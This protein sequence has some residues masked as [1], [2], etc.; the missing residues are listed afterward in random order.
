MMLVSLNDL[1]CIR[2]VEAVKEYANANP[3]RAPYATMTR[4]GRLEDALGVAEWQQRLHDQGV[5]LNAW[6]QAMVAWQA[7]PQGSPPERPVTQTLSS[8]DAPTDRPMTEAD[9]KWIVDATK[10][11]QGEEVDTKT[12]LPL[13]GDVGTWHKVYEQIFDALRDAKTAPEGG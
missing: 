8:T 7:N 2:L 1:A 4:L 6:Q 10:G 5:A 9:H 11:W 12:T 13:P 3:K